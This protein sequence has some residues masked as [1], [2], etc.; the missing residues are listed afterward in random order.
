[1]SQISKQG[2]TLVRQNVERPLRVMWEIIE[3][4]NLTDKCSDAYGHIFKFLDEVD[5]WDNNVS[6]T[7]EPNITVN[8]KKYT[9]VGK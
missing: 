2:A 7:A 5:G 9:E 6:G 4:N 3:A 8:G 1:M